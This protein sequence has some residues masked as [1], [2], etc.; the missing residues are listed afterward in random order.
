MIQLHIRLAGCDEHV[1]HIHVRE[2]GHRFTGIAQSQ[3]IRLET[4]LLR[5]QSAGERSFFAD[6][7]CGARGLP[8]LGERRGQFRRFDRFAVLLGY[9]GAF[10]HKRLIALEYHVLH[11]VGGESDG[12][13]GCGVRSGGGWRLAVLRFVEHRSVTPL[14]SAAD[15]GCDDHRHGHGDG[16][17]HVKQS[18]CVQYSSS[19]V[20]CSFKTFV[21]DMELCTEEPT[22]TGSF[23]D[24]HDRCSNGSTHADERLCSTG[25]RFKTPFRSFF[26]AGLF[27]ILLGAV[28]LQCLLEFLGLL[29]VCHARGLRLFC[30]CG[31]IDLAVEGGR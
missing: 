28:L 4:C 19:S 30:G 6:L 16:E 26:F 1:T 7:R 29:V 15:D 21:S 12:N 8:A 24:C 31:R 25:R 5:L 17:C 22:L 27:L 3:R 23:A 13:G 14:G 11:V 9:D 18:F 20:R 2:L 10:D